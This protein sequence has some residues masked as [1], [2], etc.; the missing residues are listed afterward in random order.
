[1]KLRR[2]GF[3]LVE[4]IVVIVIIGILA[5]IAAPSMT[6]NVTRARRQEAVAALGALRTAYRL[7]NAE[8][9]VAPTSTADLNALGYINI[10]ELNGPNYNNTNYAVG[11][12]NLTA[13]GAAANG[14]GVNMNTTTGV[15]DNP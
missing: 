12:V 5:A 13:T 11:A 6:A 4:L 9:G 15:I 2:K 7:Y 14:G 8:R 1:M 3:T 10:A